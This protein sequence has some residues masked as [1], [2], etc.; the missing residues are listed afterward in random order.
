M[1][2]RREPPKRRGARRTRCRVWFQVDRTRL[3]SSPPQIAMS[4][5]E[6]EQLAHAVQRLLQRI[7]N[8]RCVRDHT[9]HSHGNVF[10]G[11]SGA[12]IAGLGWAWDSDSGAGV[13]VEVEVNAMVKGASSFT[14]AVSFCSSWQRCASFTVCGSPRFKSPS[15]VFEPPAGGDISAST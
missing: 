6:Y 9:G 3:P 13:G 4:G 14:T 10:I 12:D 7:I 2:V 8:A 11:C 1:S 15:M 5:Q